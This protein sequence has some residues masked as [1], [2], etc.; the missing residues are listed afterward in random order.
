M[1]SAVNANKP[2]GGGLYCLLGCDHL[3]THCSH[4]YLRT[5]ASIEPALE[6]AS[7]GI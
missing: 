6:E 5:F 7:H 2:W 3:S 4:L 1:A